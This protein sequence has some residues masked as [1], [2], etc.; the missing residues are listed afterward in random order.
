MFTG[1]V[2]NQ[3]M[4]LNINKYVLDCVFLS[5]TAHV[6]VKPQSS[7]LAA[8]QARRVFWL[9]RSRPRRTDA[10]LECHFSFS[11]RH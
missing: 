1:H 3:L 6:S 10:G 9:F 7:R 8:A 4:D 2:T 11:G 5:N